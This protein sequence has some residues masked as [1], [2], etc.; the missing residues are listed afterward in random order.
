MN[1]RKVL[2]E[3]IM[4]SRVELSLWEVLGIVKKEFHDSIVDLVKRILNNKGD[5]PIH[6]KWRF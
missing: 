4:D 2:E 1:L 3:R 5:V 6:Y